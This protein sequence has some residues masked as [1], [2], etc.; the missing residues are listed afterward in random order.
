MWWPADNDQQTLHL[1]TEQLRNN[2]LSDPVK[3]RRMLDIIFETEREREREVWPFTQRK[4]SRY[5][6]SSSQ[7]VMTFS[8]LW[9]N[10]C[11][12]KVWMFSDLITAAGWRNQSCFTSGKQMD[13]WLFVKVMKSVKYFKQLQNNDWILKYEFVV[14]QPIQLSICSCRVMEAKKTSVISI[15]DPWENNWQCVDGTHTHTHI[16]THTQWNTDSCCD[17]A[18][19]L[20]HTLVWDIHE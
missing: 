13:H 9:A 11:Q 14:K 18:G 12:I 4:V 3:N 7:D 15:N 1:E 2:I 20:H 6:S 5:K 17:P 10:Y 16:H 19:S 8:Q